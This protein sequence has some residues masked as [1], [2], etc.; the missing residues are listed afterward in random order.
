MYFVYLKWYSPVLRR[1]R[2][3][4]RNQATAVANVSQ[5]DC[6]DYQSKEL[7]SEKPIPR[8]TVASIEKQYR[9]RKK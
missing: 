4:I 5:R 3:V 6:F 7:R 2:T 1:K 9:E 8:R